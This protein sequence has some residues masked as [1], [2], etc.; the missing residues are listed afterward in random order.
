MLHINIK[1][2]VIFHLASFP[3]SNTL[4][5]STIVVVLFLFL[6]LYVSH[7]GRK[8]TLAFLIRYICFK[9][10]D[11]INSILK[12]KTKEYF[13]LLASLFL[14]ILFSNWL[15]LIPPV[16][17]L[18]V[19]DVHSHEVPLLKGSTAD[20]NTTLGL[21]IL[22][23]VVLQISGIKYLGLGGYGG[24][25]FNFKSPIDFFTGIL[26]LVSEVSKV[27]SFAFRLFGNIFAGEVLILVM[28]FL[29]PVLASFPFLM[30]EIFVGFIQALVFMML[31]AVFLQVATTGHHEV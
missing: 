31:T 27:I 20:L 28:V 15:G 26:E 4:L 3:V 8:S 30:L 29:I 11:L 24:K 7:T 25:F 9:L 17:S 13:P 10:N 14:Y 2:D 5:A 6:S 1:P 18:I 12:D 22:V 23:F 16:G 21:A 19:A